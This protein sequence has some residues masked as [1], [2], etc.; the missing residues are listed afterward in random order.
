MRK[1]EIA[2]YKQFLLFSGC[3]LPLY[4][5]S[6][7]KC[8]IVCNRLNIVSKIFTRKSGHWFGKIVVLMVQKKSLIWWT[9]TIC[10]SLSS[11]SWRRIDVKKVAQAGN[12]N[13]EKSR[14]Y[15]KNCRNILYPN[16][17]PHVSHDIV[18]TKGF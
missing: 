8:V 2:F 10:K 13:A 1:G 4:I 16:M 7:S 5:F 15:K 6:A 9:D 17:N 11:E 3:F 12:N 18:W 14:N